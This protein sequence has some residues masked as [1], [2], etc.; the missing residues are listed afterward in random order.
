MARQLIRVSL[1]LATIVVVGGSTDAAQSGIRSGPMWQRLMAAHMASVGQRSAAAAQQCPN[2]GGVCSSVVVPLDR[3][4]PGGAQIRVRYELFAHTDTARRALPPIFLSEGGPGGS[5]LND[6]FAH[7]A[8]VGM[9]KELNDRHDIVAIDQRGVGQSGVIV[10]PALQAG[11][12][13]LFVAA[14]G[15]GEQLGNRSDLYG[16][17]D[18]A[19]DFDAIRRALG[20]RTIDFFGSSY[21]GVDIQSYAVRYPSHLHRAVLDSPAFPRVD[22]THHAPD[23]LLR[24]I[25]QLCDLSAA[26][27]PAALHPRRQLVWL[28]RH[29]R[30]HPLDGIGVDDLGNRHHVHLT[31]GYLIW[32][33]LLTGEPF[34]GDSEVAA[35]AVAL[36]HG[37]TR[38][39]LRLA[40]ENDHPISLGGPDPSVFSAGANDA[41]SCTDMPWQWNDRAPES[42]RRSQFAAWVHNLPADAY[43]PFSVMGWLVPYPVGIGSTECIRW[44]APTHRRAKAVP[45]GA[46]FPDIPALVLSGSVDLTVPSEDARSV[47]REFPNSVFVSIRGSGHDTTLNT[48][49][50]C[51]QAIAIHFL[52]TGTTGDTSCAAERPDFIFPAV[53]AFPQTIAG[54]RQALRRPGD[55]STAAERRAVSSAW[56]AIRDTLWH[57]YVYGTYPDDNSG[58][59]LH[60]GTFHIHFD[61][62][63]NTTHLQLHRMRFTKDL[64]VS[65]AA[66]HD[67]NAVVHATITV[68]GAVNGRLH[69]TGIWLAP[70]ATAIQITGTLDGHRVM[71]AEPTN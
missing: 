53:Q 38:P 66:I 31:E 10:C 59:G 68:R 5:I 49:S 16:S 27:S 8:W 7:G 12:I 4:H 14:H 42:V 17:S 1:L 51:A 43:A 56:D 24:V 64:S 35:A 23:S 26:C 21:A 20:A 13:N 34:I 33:I 50:Q 40:A 71:L 46:T 44:P 54:E 2:D 62:A 29:L 6:Q 63:H 36:R 22:L 25:P 60:G 45:A 19:A 57:Q 55:H 32:R 69:L 39:L 11:I 15:C 9:L 65:G 3:D 70:T 28:A 58:P 67:N 47:A 41:R 30:R 37:D 18:V 52:R 61:T 48:H